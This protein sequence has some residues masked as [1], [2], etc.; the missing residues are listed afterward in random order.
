MHRLPCHEVYTPTEQVGELVLQIVDCE[1]E[2]GTETRSSP[3]G[4]G[5]DDPRGAAV[6]FGV[7]FEGGRMRCVHRPFRDG[8]FSGRR[9]SGMVM[10]DPRQHE[11]S[12]GFDGLTEEKITWL[13]ADGAVIDSMEVTLVPVDTAETVPG[14]GRGGRQR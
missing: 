7:R 9:G 6:Q 11:Q 2:A 8:T 5:T 10:D 14:S 4:E 13:D 1:S 12:K 3:D